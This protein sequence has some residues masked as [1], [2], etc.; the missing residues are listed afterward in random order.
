MRPT[1][2]DIAKAAGVSRTTVSNVMNRRD[3][4][5]AEVRDRVLL[6][7]KELGYTRN[8]AAKTLVDHRS[9]LVGLVFPSY[10]DSRLLTKSPFYN[11]IIDAVDGK[12]R[13]T[14]QYDLIIHCASSERSIRDWALYRSL[15]GLILVGD[16][17]DGELEDLD[18]RKLP[19]VI[20]DGYTS[21]LEG[22]IRVNTDDEEG[23]YLAGREFVRRGCRRCGAVTTDIVHSPVNQRRLSGFR[24]ALREEG[25]AFSHFEAINNFF[26]GG[27]DSAP[28][29]AESSCGGIF[30]V[31][32]MLAAGL[33]RGLQELGK[34]IPDDLGLI[35]F[36]NLDIAEWVSPELTTVD[37]DIFQKGTAAIEYLLE[38]IEGGNPDRSHVLP[39]RLVRR[40][41]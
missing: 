5:S 14:A 12:L 36:D 18:R 40:K 37:Q 22:P 30:A 31:N 15:D 6:A 4:C 11:L 13:G 35:G 9:S 32:D 23:G 16:F 39:V 20:I 33:L 25:L 17:P 19:M 3:R 10:L 7:A 24:R 28:R 41:T 26:D 8:M 29:V 38:A 21:S 2:I 1:V 27:L 34:R